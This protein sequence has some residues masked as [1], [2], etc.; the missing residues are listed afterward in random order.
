MRRGHFESI[1]DKKTWAKALSHLKKRDRVLAGIIKNVKVGEIELESDYYGSIVESF[2]YQQISGSAANAILK[3]FKGL[4]RGKLPK[5][6]QFL[7]TDTRKLRKA[8]LSPQK[9]SY[10][11]D[12]CERIESGNLTLQNIHRME[13]GEVIAKLD[14]V[15][16]IGRWT[17]EMFLMFTLGRTDILPADDLGIKNAI[18]KNYKLR[19]HPGRD[20]L[21]M[22]KKKWS[23]Y[24]TVASIYMWRSLESKNWKEG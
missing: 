12:L 11:K 8:G 17:A 14:E 10:I 6:R 20:Y 2:V 5:P 21:A 19:Q 23:P 4:Y 9:I 1:D 24:S 13:D 18:R 7:V 15:K 16:G 22:L 3:K